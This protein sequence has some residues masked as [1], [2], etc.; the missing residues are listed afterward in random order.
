MAIDR[1]SEVQWRDWGA[2]AL[3][4]AER[5][6]RII[7]L[8]ISAS[9]CH[10]C[11][12]M[13]RTTY[14][15]SEIIRFINEHFVPI[16]VDA[17]KRPDIQDRYLLGGWPTTAFLLPDG[18]MLSGTTFVPPEAMIR[19]LHE[20]DDLYREHKSLVTAQAASMTAEAEAERTEAETPVT[21]F[22]TEYID[23]ADSVIKA[24]FDPVNGS[25]GREPKF[26]YPDAIRFA[27]RRYRK[28]NDK[29][30]LRIATETLDKMMALYD[31]V[32]GGFYRYAMNA[33]WSN[34]HYEKLLY[35]QASAIDNYTEA[36]QVTG[37]DKYGE[38]AA[39][40]KAYAERFLADRDKGGFYA[41]QDA[42]IGS[43]DPNEDLILGDQYFPLSEEDRLSIGTPYV[44]KTVYTDWNGMMAS[45]YLKLFSVMGDEHAR[46]FAMKTIDRLLSES[47]AGDRM[48]HFTDGGPQLCGVLG[49]QVYFGQAL[50]DAYQASGLRR[51]LREAE[52]LA[53]FMSRELQDVVDGGFYF[54]TFDPHMKGEV[55][56]RHKPFDENM[57]AAQFLT[58]LFYLSGNENYRNLAAR[59]LT[60]LAY[61][62][63]VGNI[64]GVSY[65][66]ALEQFLT[67]PLHIVVVGDRENKE[68]QEMLET[69]LHAYEPTKLVQFLDPDEDS[70]T[71]GDTTYEAD[72]ETLAYV[73]VQDT[74]HPPVKGN[75]DLAV[76]LENVIGGTPS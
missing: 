23:A 7:L 58:Q 67:R 39:G 57:V 76:M 26:P 33:D 71:I 36:Y 21:Q 42:D 24:D 44:D 75:N 74:C 3:S 12:V 27:F 72:E 6:D 50:I 53:D 62:Q 1:S 64:V 69:S 16:R 56:E 13:D 25:F 20:V 11:H 9:W 41:S 34:P 32:W 30:M 29:D 4:Q 18:R 63:L 51:Y 31:P 8:D 68:T 37:D 66:L 70:L 73:C 43:H 61:P 55:L 49:D 35:A 65:A 48:C 46:D 38:I 19:K 54:Q 52:G 5:E 40:V 2:E 28:T 17:D 14:S 60:A 45:A 15:N 47:K 22:H 59:T 10:W